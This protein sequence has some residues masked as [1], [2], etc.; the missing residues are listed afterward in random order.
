MRAALRDHETHQAMHKQ[1]LKHVFS[2]VTL[3]IFLL[4]GS[5]YLR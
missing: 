2:L 3:P 1:T 4:E 5:S